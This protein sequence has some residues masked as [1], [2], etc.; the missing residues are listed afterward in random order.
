MLVRVV[1]LLI[2]RSKVQ[3]DDL[4]V[5]HGVFVRLSHLAP[6]LVFYY[7]SNVLFGVE[8]L[9]WEAFVMRAST[10]W[11]IL[12]GARSAGA[13][14][15]CLVEL[16]GNR[17]ATRDK[18][19]GSYAQVIKLL[20]WLTVFIVALGIMMD[21]SPL[22]L[23]TGLGAMTAVILLVFKDSILGF[24]A[25]IQIASYDMVRVGDWVE[26]P[27]FGADGDVVEISLNTVKIQNWDKTISTVPTYAFM[28]DSFKNWRGMSE[29]GGRR[30]KRS[31]SLDMGSVHLLNQEEISGLRDI[32]YIQG[33]LEKKSNEVQKWNKENGVNLECPVNGRR[34]TNLGTFRAYVESYLRNHPQI[35]QDM[36]FLVRQ[37]APGPEGVPI[38]IYVFSAE[39]RWSYYEAIIGDIFDHLIAVVPEFGLKVYQRP[40]GADIS[41]LSQRTQ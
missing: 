23:L 9:A 1:H 29:S 11:M 7:A 34:L 10:V 39:Q 14:L 38:E 19:M 24:V 18:P 35:R 16:A 2:H 22:V 17:K 26:L 6:A 20:I 41:S 4:L 30:I 8:N 32:Q 21:R 25:S 28:S 37:L 12:A 36:T 27:K 40:S 15:D 13:F 5:K 33:Y 31:I 3:W